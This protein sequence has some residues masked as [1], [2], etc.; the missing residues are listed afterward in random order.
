MSTSDLPNVRQN[1]HKAEITPPHDRE[2]VSFILSVL[3]NVFLGCRLHK[4]TSPVLIT[5][6]SAVSGYCTQLL[7]VTAQRLRRKLILWEERRKESSVCRVFVC[8]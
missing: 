3:L 6:I 1:I 7:A 5:V 4:L 8:R 2:D